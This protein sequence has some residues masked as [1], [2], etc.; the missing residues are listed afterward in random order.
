MI[1]DESDIKLEGWSEALCGW[2]RVSAEKQRG[3]QGKLYAPAAPNQTQELTISHFIRNVDLK[4]LNDK[5]T[6]ACCLF[7]LA[8][9]PS[10]PT[11]ESLE[12]SRQLLTDLV[13]CRKSRERGPLART[14]QLLTH[15]NRD[16]PG[17]RETTRATCQHSHAKRVRELAV[18][19]ESS[20]RDLFIRHSGRCL[21]RNSGFAKCKSTLVFSRRW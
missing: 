4:L 8:L 10:L 17:L 13:F 3:N 14:G 16:S 21:C 20:A 6:I 15:G 18:S 19:G 1:L 12:A 2:K 5:V 11:S 9:R 7:S